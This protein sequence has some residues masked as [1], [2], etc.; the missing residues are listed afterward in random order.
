MA[1]ATVVPIIRK[2]WHEK[3][4]HVVGQLI[5]LGG[6]YE[7]ELAVNDILLVSNEYR[8]VSSITS[9]LV[10][11]VANAYS[12][13][14]NDR[15]PKRL[16]VLTTITGA[17][18]VTASAS[19]VG[20]GT[21]FLSEVSKGD[22]L[23]IGTAT[24]GEARPVSSIQSDLALTVETAFTDLANDAAPQIC[25][26]VNPA[27][28][29]PD[30]TVLTGEIDPAASAT[31]TGVNTQFLGQGIPFD[32]TLADIFSSKAPLFMDIWSRRAGLLYTLSNREK[33]QDLTGTVDTTASATVAGVGTLFLQELVVG[34]EILVGI[35]RRFVTAIASNTSLTVHR[36]HTDQANDT[37]P[38]KVIRDAKLFDN[39][40][41]VR[42]L[43]ILG[44]QAVVGTRALYTAT[45][46]TTFDLQKEEAANA[47]I[48]MGHLQTAAVPNIVLDDLIEFHAAF[49][50]G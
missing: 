46:G 23:V 45:P 38:Q 8:Q 27:T 11:V 41:E 34:D 40:L 2:K 48:R 14:A 26:I 4:I 21:K 10:A 18:D 12:N 29:R 42:G 7:T 16:D 9:D 36:A 20:V 15:A 33:L 50:L 1:R 32:L 22:L 13:N 25:R 30:F 44:G 47:F 39:R 24:V 17:I 37:T 35:E 31:V 49:D 5:V 28:G 19:V 6:S 3:K 43:P